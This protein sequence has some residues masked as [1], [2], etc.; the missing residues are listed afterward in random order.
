MSE[1]P[2][3]TYQ[4]KMK[5]LSIFETLRAIAVKILVQ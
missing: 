5:K 3:K 2:T 1:I 4:E